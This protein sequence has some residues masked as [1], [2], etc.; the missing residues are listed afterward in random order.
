MN[1]TDVAW[2]QDR[3]GRRA[4]DLRLD[5]HPAHFQTN[6][7]SDLLELGILAGVSRLRS[8]RRDIKRNPY[9]Q[10]SYA[11]SQAE[12]AGCTDDP[13]AYALFT[14][15][16]AAIR[17]G[18]WAAGDRP[19]PVPDG[20]GS[21]HMSGGG[22]LMSE[23]GTPGTSLVPGHCLHCNGSMV[24]HDGTTG[25]NTCQMCARTWSCDPAQAGHER[26]AVVPAAASADLMRTP[27]RRKWERRP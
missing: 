24:I 25:E 20:G 18:S 10:G 19:D 8:E 2:V 23:T 5:G 6:Q 9:I 14:E 7:R 26:C 22:E 3:P 16:C 21:A 27:I 12:L 1:I 4:L 17:A 13:G 15:M 11:L